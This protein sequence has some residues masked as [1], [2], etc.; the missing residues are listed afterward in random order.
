[1]TRSVRSLSGS[2]VPRSFDELE[3]PH[4]AETPSVAHEREA[5]EESAEAPLDLVPMALA[6]SGRRCRSIDPI[7]ARAAAQETGFPA[8]V[9]PRPP[10]C[11]LSMIS[12]RPVTAEIGSP[13][14]SDL[15]IVM[16]SGSR[17]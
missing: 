3:R 11:A 9:P 14:P 12:A 7:A 16:M 15:A 10:T 4:R 17:S 13:P 6:R 1:M 5:V 2:L 8:Y